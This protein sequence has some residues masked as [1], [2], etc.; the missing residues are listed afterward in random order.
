MWK[1]LTRALLRNRPVILIFIVFLTAF[2]G[3]KGVGVKLS[4]DNASILPADDSFVVDY[5]TFKKRFGE[6]GSVIVIGVEN[7]SMF[8]LKDFNLWYDLT[9][10]M[11]KIEGV[12]GVMSIT[13][14]ATIQKND[15]LHQFDFNQLVTSKPTT[16]SGVDS[17]KN[18]ILAQR[19]YDGLLFNSKTDVYILAITLKKAVLNDKIRMSITDNIV[20]RAKEYTA[21]SGHELHYSGLP[22]IRT[23]TARTV[24]HELFLFVLLS[25]IVAAFILYLFFRSL[26][27]VASSLVVVGISIVFT[28]GLVGLFGF[29][30]SILTG[31]IPSLIVVIA[32]ENCIYI[33]NKYHWEY[34]NHGN[35]ILAL[36]RV[37]RRIGFASLMVNTA[38]AAGFAA[39][40]LVSN[41]LLR[42][43]G[44]IASISIMMEYALCITLLPIIFSYMNP[45][46]DKHVKHLDNNFFNGVLEKIFFVIQHKRGWVFSIAGLLLLI[47]IVG[48]LNMRTSGKVTDDI[49]HGNPLYQDLKFFEKQLGGVMPFEI[50]VDTKKKKGVMLYS[51]IQRIDQLQNIIS[52]NK[53]FSK[54]LSIAEFTKFAKQAYFNGN[55]EMYTLPNSMEKTFVL[56]YLP[57]KTDGKQQL[58]N[59]FIDSTQ[60][61]TRVSFQM[62]DIGTKEMNRLLSSIRPQVDSIFAKADYDVKITGSSVIYTR[63]TEFLIKHLLVSVLIAVGFISLLMALMF[64]S[65]RMIAVSMLPNIIP[66]IITAAIMGFTGV[67]IKPSTIIVFSIALGISVDNTIQ[68][69]SRYRH[70]L[71]TTGNNIKLS[72]LNA[73]HEA[74]FSMIYTSIVLV[75]GFSVFMVSSFG[76][77]Q[78]L[79]LLVSTTL[80]IAMFFNII[81]LPSLLLVLDKYLVTKAF[82]SE[83]VIDIDEDQDEG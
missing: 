79:G 67:P 39:F 34:R 27:V 72:T 44:I 57:K 20:D 26:K 30:I 29:K 54:P 55:P 24:Q 45:P 19:F 48:M 63:G 71:K 62:A 64:S 12:E 33:L 81:V 9:A 53:E 46:S 73:L 3:W 13:K 2:M 58:L 50:S 82:K 80:F 25:I 21:Q 36:S 56:S 10:D 1:Y 4:Y 47:G 51:T 52:K 22:Y 7:P 78:A 37:I 8:Q 74:G 66:L 68:Y 65:V 76:G 83:P 5:A 70:E 75:L 32:I 16:Q 23:M 14:A 15:S 6:D 35:K 42:E 69:L 60:Q 18:K 11:T 77:T 59:S 28:L 41:Q 38:T 43:F 61:I 31:V 17:L 40:I 49:H